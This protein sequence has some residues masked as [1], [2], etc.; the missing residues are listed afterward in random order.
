MTITNIRDIRGENINWVALGK[1]FKKFRETS[2]L[3]QLEVAQTLGIAETTMDHFERGHMSEGR[4]SINIIW[5]LSM[6]WNLSLNWLLNGLGEPHDPD[7]LELMPET[8]IVQRGAGIRRNF[9]RVQAEE[10]EFTDH[11]FEF[12][13]AIDKFK[14]KNQVPFPSL[15]QLYDIITALGYRKSVPARIAPLG[16]IVEH[17]QRA[18]KF[19]QMNEKIEPSLDW[20]GKELHPERSM[21]CE[22]PSSAEN[23]ALPEVEKRRTRRKNRRRIKLGL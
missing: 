23:N 16:Y 10:G 2:Y 5:H 20:A 19:K 13:L 18:E 12:V 6:Q 11:I 15:T 21:V 14:S 9:A 17:Q 1:R 22:T 8:L 4:K 3:S 7:P